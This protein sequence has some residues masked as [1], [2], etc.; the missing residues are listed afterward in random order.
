MATEL[1]AMFRSAM[2]D[3][4]MAESEDDIFKSSADEGREPEIKQ[5]IK[6]ESAHESVRAPEVSE[7]DIF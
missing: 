5:E 7:D 2:K 6:Q 3:E 4:P 1:K